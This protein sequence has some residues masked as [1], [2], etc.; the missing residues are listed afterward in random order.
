[1]VTP[2]TTPYKPSPLSF[3]SPRSSPFRRQSAASS[4]TTVRPNV[5][6][7][8]GNN[9][10]SPGQSPSMLNQ[11]P[12]AKEEDVF[13]NGSGL[14]ATPRFSGLHP[15]PTRGA[16]P[17]SPEFTNPTSLKARESQSVNSDVLSRLPAAQLREMREAF[18]VLDRDNDGQI[19]KED[20]AKILNNLGRDSSA[21]VTAAYF[22]PGAPRAMN[23]PT[24]LNTIAALLAP[25]SD[26]QELLNA[27]A[28]FDEDDSG[29]IDLAELRDALLNTLPEGDERRLTE[30]EIDEVVFG[31]TGRR[32]FGTKGAKTAN[33]NASRHRA[34]VFRYQDFVTNL[35]GPSQGTK[36][37]VAKA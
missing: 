28:A 22:P 10:T 20:V 23:L 19:N 36:N 1:M 26:P 21:S 12:T 7:S 24:Y 6:A 32:A 27:F 17:Q 13:A 25:L 35:T 16:R 9:Q 34:E 3:G 5:S 4:P 18:Q 14:P 29:Q 15:S 31:F 33:L 11:L 8:L 37:S 30:R 2:N